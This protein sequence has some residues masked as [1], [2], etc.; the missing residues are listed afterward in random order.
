M[1]TD[2]FDEKG[3]CNACSSTYIKRERC[4][5]NKEKEVHA[6]AHIRQG[7]KVRMDYLPIAGRRLWAGSVPEVFTLTTD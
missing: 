3:F 4:A 5:T 6:Q 2:L 7:D 1:T